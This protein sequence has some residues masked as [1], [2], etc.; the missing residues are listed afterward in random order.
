MAERTKTRRWI[1]ELLRWSSALFLLSTLAQAVL[2]GLFVTG[3]VDLLMWHDVNAQIN[4]SVLLVVL[5]A[6]ILLWRPARASSWPFWITLA[7][8]TIVEIQKTL[9]YLRSVSFHIIL[10]VLIF[11][12]ASVLTWWAFGYQLPPQRAKARKK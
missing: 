2:A 9:G 10:G 4:S 6:T 3:E 7:L 12:M 11:G 5:L 1:V 8:V